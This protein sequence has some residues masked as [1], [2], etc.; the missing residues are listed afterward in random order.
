MREQ[1]ELVE[2]DL[3]QYHGLDYRDRWRYDEVVTPSGRRVHLRKLTTRM[4][5]ARIRHLPPTSALAIFYN[6][7]KWPWS[8][9]DHLIADLWHEQEVARIGKK[10]KDHPARP[11]VSAASKAGPDRDRRM[12]DAKRRARQE[13]AARNRRRATGGE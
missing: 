4:I 8:L 12:R 10:A 2:A 7:G 11:R 5:Y 9:T 6:G 1:E 3:S 13:A